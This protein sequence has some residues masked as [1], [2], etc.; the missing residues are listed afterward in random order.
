MII[1]LKFFLIDKI[2]LLVA[3]KCGFD[4]FG[5]GDVTNSASHIEQ[6]IEGTIARLGFAPDLYYLHRI[7][8]SA[9]DNCTR[10]VMMRVLILCRNPSRGIYYNSRQDPQGRENQVYWPI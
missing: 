8:P 7:D 2:L 4:V 10:N 3:S 9:S 5:K 1:L 6:Y